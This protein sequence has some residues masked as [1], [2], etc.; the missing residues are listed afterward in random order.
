MKSI[1][2]AI[3]NNYYSEIEKISEVAPCEKILLS[4]EGITNMTEDERFYIRIE[5]WTQR[6]LNKEINLK[7]KEYKKESV[8]RSI[9]KEFGSKKEYVIE[10]LKERIN[11]T[12][13][14]ILKAQYNNFIFILSK[15][16][17]YCQEAIQFYQKML[18]AAFR[19]THREFY[20][21]HVDDI[22]EKILDLSLKIKF[23]IDDL[24]KQVMSFLTDN[25]MA[26]RLKTRLFLSV[27]E[28]EKEKKFFSNKESAGFPSIFISLA[29][30]CSDTIWVEHNLKIALFYAAKNQNQ[31]DIQKIYELLGDN[32][33]KN[34]LPEDDS[35]ILIP[36]HNEKI[37]EKI[38][39]YYKKAKCG[40]KLKHICESHSKNKKNK[41][42]IPII[43][44]HKI[45]KEVTEYKNNFLAEISNMQLID[46]V[47]NLIDCK[48]FLFI[49]HQRLNSMV[50]ESKDKFFYQKYFPPIQC[51]INFNHK[52]S[53]VD[54][55]D[56]Y[57]CYAIGMNYN[58]DFI[59]NFILNCIQKEKLSYEKLHHILNKDKFFGEYCP[60][61][62]PEEEIT[63]TWL[64][65]IDVG[66]ENFFI[67]CNQVLED[68][69]PDW[70]IC[71]DVLT[72]KFEGIL[73]NMLDL[74]GATITKYAEN[75]SFRR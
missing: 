17:T 39:E 11:T 1:G 36:Y 41:K 59:F 62:N 26:D 29:E 54:N 15:D 7:N 8:E 32:E 60:K 51:D 45:S 21:L 72:P 19:D 9:L 73:R 14:N 34:I 52:K 68:K 3:L 6:I 2:S 70:R 56:K 49:P 57:F 23:K 16:S 33:C 40:Q 43:I 71:I 30:S 12:S 69:T 74:N 10:Y 46:I 58:L 28:R 24:K 31:Q 65:M 63:D 35:N 66:L 4:I 27:I 67:Q 64:S 75:T 53:D 13:N 50:K 44:E 55:N 25:S 47:K 48:K 38:I 20:E 5:Y 22:F 37:Y 42:F 61:K 18:Q